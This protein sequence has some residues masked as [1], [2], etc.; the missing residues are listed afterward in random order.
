MTVKMLNRSKLIFGYL[1]RASSDINHI[2]SMPALFI[3]LTKFVSIISFAFAYIYTFIHTND[4]LEKYVPA[5]P[6]LFFADWI[7][8]LILLSAADLPVNQVVGN[9]NLQRAP[10][11]KTNQ[12]FSSQFSWFDNIKIYVFR[13]AFFA[14]TLLPSP[15][16]KMRFKQ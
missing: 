6:F 13:F 10:H 7:R 12:I 8:I 15:S 11:N 9:S 16:P 2:F 1:C 14:N 5:L 3:L 4:V